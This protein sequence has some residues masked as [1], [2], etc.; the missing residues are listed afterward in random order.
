MATRLRV[1]VDE[2][3]E[4]EEV[5][6]RH[7][8]LGAQQG[9]LSGPFVVGAL[10]A[11]VVSEAA[12]LH[13]VKRPVA[14]D[15]TSSED[16]ADEFCADNVR[17]RGGLHDVPF[18]LTHT[19]QHPAEVVVA[20]VAA[21]LGA[22]VDK[23][24]KHGQI[25]ANLWLCAV[26]TAHGEVLLGPLIT[27]ALEAN[28]VCD[29]FHLLSVQVAVAVHVARMER[30]ADHT[31]SPRGTSVE[32]GLQLQLLQDQL[33]F[34][35]RVASGAAIVDDLD[36]LGGVHALVRIRDAAAAH[37]AVLF[38][39]VLLT[40]LEASSLR[41]GAHLRLV[42]ELVPVLVA[43][44]EDRADDGSTRHW[45]QGVASPDTA[46]S[47]GTTQETAGPQL[48][49]DGG[50]LHVTAKAPTLRCVVHKLCEGS[51]IHSFLGSGFNFGAKHPVLLVPSVVVAVEASVTGKGPH[52]YDVQATIPILVARLEDCGDEG[53]T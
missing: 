52:L 35:F 21:T 17:C 20:A 16:R 26:V 51:Q 7:L 33:Q 39:P 4:Q 30:R 34:R 11:N 6:T 23:H 25:N 38:G 27:R 3:F 50:K 13:L 32:A 49:D 53:S 12:H 42:Q 41:E 5:D 43:E 8:L 31:G 15:V 24:L 47:V 36:E 2:L 28:L 37:K 14:V 1:V 40:S 22:V 10:E 44:V 45:S 19:L 46:C 9:K 18:Q 48:P 29:V